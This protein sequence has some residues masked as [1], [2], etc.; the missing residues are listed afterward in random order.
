[1]HTTLRLTGGAI[2]QGL[3]TAVGAAIAAPDRQV[4]AFQADGSGLYT[5]QS[6]WTMAREQL[7]VTVVIAANNAYHI[8]QVELG[9][10]G[11]EEPG[12]AAR[13]L[14]DLTGPVLDWIQIAR[15]FGVPARRAST[16]EELAAAL[17]N[18]FNEPGPCLIEAVLATS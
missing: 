2:G 1:M 5:V 18:G 3:P 8:L 12:P 4:L 13:S 11:I 9:R 10:A 6:L 7:D 17:A 14:T 16:A 15:G